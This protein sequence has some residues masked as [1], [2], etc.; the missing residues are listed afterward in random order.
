VITKGVGFLPVLA[1]IPA[2]LLGARGWPVVRGSRLLW[3]AGPLAMAGAIALWLVPMWIAT[4]ASPELTAYRNELLFHQTLTRYG[5]A[6]HH[7]E[8][9]T[10]FLTHVIPWAWLPT[11]VLLPWLLPRW[12][13]ALRARNTLTVVLLVWVLLVIAFFSASTGKRGVYILPALPAL[14]MAAAP[15][16]PELLRARGP[17]RLVF[18]LTALLTAVFATAAVYVALG[19]ARMKSVDAQMLAD[20]LAPLATA[21]LGCALV[22]AAFRVR[23]AWLAWTGAV[24]VVLLVTG[25]MIYQRLDAARSGRGFAQRVTS[26][27]ADVRELGLVDVRE[28]F[29]LHLSRP[30]V[31]FGRDRW[32]EREREAADAA[33]W[34]AR[35][36]QRALIVP[37]PALAMCFKQARA[38]PLGRWHREDWFLIRG[39]ADPDCA[40]RGNAAAARLYIPPAHALN[41]YG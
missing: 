34:L 2:G 14:V 20:A 23:D 7:L 28:Q 6:W 39:G 24:G 27:A 29:V 13:G 9:P 36:T 38:E 1:L 26:A 12:R 3:I 32:R 33:A 30:L 10:Y 21:A 5:E 35:D 41:T 40:S 17:R 37:K 4:S 11:I 25:F 19:D 18:A 31:H 8:P 22:L 15:W 16:L